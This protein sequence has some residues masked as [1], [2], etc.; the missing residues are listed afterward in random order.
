[1]GFVDFLLLGV[2]FYWLF[3]PTGKLAASLMLA[4]IAASVPI[5]GVAVARQMDVLSLLDQAQVVGLGHEQLQVH[6]LMALQGFNN[7]FQV[8]NIF[9]GLWLVPLGWLVF[10]CGFMPRFLGVLLVMGSLYYLASF[11]GAVFDPHYESSMLGRSIGI[12]SGIP[13]FVGESGTILWLVIMGARDGK[14][15]LRLHE[16]AV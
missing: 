14:T 16:A 7:L 13:G 6:L 4:F 2:V 1:M 5:Y 10:R 9:S 12:L 3:S 8:T 11:C 15:E